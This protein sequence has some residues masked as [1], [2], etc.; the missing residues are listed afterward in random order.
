A[1]LELDEAWA[2]LTRGVRSLSER[3]AWEVAQS[4]Y[5]QMIAAFSDNP[6]EQDHWDARVG[7]TVFQ[8]EAVAS[9]LSNPWTV[10]PDAFKRYRMEEWCTRKAEE[11]ARVR[12]LLLDELGMQR[13][14]QAIA[15]ACQAAAI[16]LAEG[17]QR[18]FL[19]APAPA[20]ST[21]VHSTTNRPAVP[22]KGLL[23]G[24]AA[25]VKPVAKT[26][27]AWG[28][29][30]DEFGAFVGHYDAARMTFDDAVKWKNHLIEQ[31]LAVRTIKYGKLAALR[32]I[33]QWGVDN[34]RL[35]ENFAAKVSV[36][37]KVGVKER[38]RGFTDEEA[39]TIL[40]AADRET[41]TYL[42]WI[43]WL[44]AFTGA[45]LSEVSQLRKED[46][47]EVE[48][49]PCVHFVPEA[50]S[51]KNSGSERAVPL[52]PALIE[53]GFL[54][55]VA[56]AKP[57]PLFKDLT[58]DRFGSRGGNGTKLIGRW[59]RGLGITDPRVSP[60]HAWRHRFKTLGRRFG[61]AEDISNAITGHGKRSVADS[62]GE[63]QMAAL[64]REL[65][66]INP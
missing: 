46:V 33:V 57:E 44:C 66:K 64:L 7:P 23:D 51:L 40:R 63:Y 24:W 56:K 65:E 17:A 45:R 59:V 54:R 29:T 16:E 30:I 49:I 18:G 52:H 43:P 21:R 27:Y 14:Q 60:S 62:Y 8:S 3:E 15:K 47:I 58:P 48:G 55:F 11:V 61:M 6:S 26:L 12:G 28:R 41:A 22:L 10:D 50:G 1:L 42:H 35:T 37:G 32:A 20:A 53:R 5:S 31:G 39:T 19:R 13:L 38:K 2:G 9:D 34:R 4:V 25:E 36:A